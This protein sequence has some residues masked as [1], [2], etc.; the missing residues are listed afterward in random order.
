[1]KIIGIIPARFASTRFPGKPLIDIKGK[2]MIQRVYENCISILSDVLVATDNS[3]ISQEVKQ[4]GGNV[5]LT[6][7]NHK[8]GTDR[9][10]EAIEKYEKQ[11]GKNFDI[12]IN[13]QGDEPFIQKE[14]LTK[15][16]S[17]F[18]DSE[19]EIATLIK[20]IEQNKDIFNPNKPKVIINKKKY[21]IYFSRSPVPYIRNHPKEEW[22]KHFNFYKHIGIYAY[23]SNI[24]SEIT[25]LQQSSLEKA[26]SLEQNRWIENNYSIS[27]DYTELESLS[28]DT[29]EDLQK[30]LNF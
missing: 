6:S 16:I 12:V 26:E 29:K 24:L 9:C 13:I 22:H 4:F 8:T 18:D 20:K 7:E 1:M 17:C 19:T 27:I 2:S 11:S 15:I 30:A 25:K 23:K 28:I 10:A 14:H 21:A 3:L 5:V